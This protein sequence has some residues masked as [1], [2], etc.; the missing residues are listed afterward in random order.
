MN[1][2]RCEGCGHVWT[3]SKKDGSIVTHVTSA[4]ESPEKTGLLDERLD[5]GC[6]R[7]FRSQQLPQA[8]DVGRLDH[9]VVEPCG[10]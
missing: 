3:T 2:Y 5:W 10:P 6:R 9:V 8:I 7:P 4:R 1:Y